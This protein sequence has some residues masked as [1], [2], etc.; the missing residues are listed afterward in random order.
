MAGAAATRSCSSHEPLSEVLRTF[1][2]N[3]IRAAKGPTLGATSSRRT[4]RA[5]MP[6]LPPLSSPYFYRGL[7]LRL[8]LLH[9]ASSFLYTTLVF[10]N[11]RLL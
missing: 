9:L 8:L 4:V 11:V 7:R 2:V 1:R 3:S 6:T 10:F 5:P